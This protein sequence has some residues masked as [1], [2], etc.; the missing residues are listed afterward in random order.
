MSL[1]YDKSSSGRYKMTHN[2]SSRADMYMIPVGSEGHDLPYHWVDR[3][4]LGTKNSFPHGAHL[5][6]DVFDGLMENFALF[7]PVP[8]CP[9][10]PCLRDGVLKLTVVEM[11]NCWPVRRL[12]RD[13]H[14]PSLPTTEAHPLSRAVQVTAAQSSTS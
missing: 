8:S 10:H 13:G 12:L 11:A 2:F 14:M 3:E 4:V 6:V 1:V 5:D 9:V 7:A